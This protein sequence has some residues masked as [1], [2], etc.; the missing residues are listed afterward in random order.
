VNL[1]PFHEARLIFAVWLAST[2]LLANLVHFLMRV[3]ALAVYRSR[4]VVRD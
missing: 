2:V 4:G 1:G 3:Q